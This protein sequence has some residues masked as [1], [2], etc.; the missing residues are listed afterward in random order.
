VNVY[1]AAWLT[2]HSLCCLKLIL[3]TSRNPDHTGNEEDRGLFPQKN[4][5]IAGR[6]SDTRA[7]GR[8]VDAVDE[9]RFDA[10]GSGPVNR[11]ARPNLFMVI[12]E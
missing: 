3:C 8:S 1:R 11:R 12:K 7:L 9:A 2:L 5:E 10:K 4:T 6:R